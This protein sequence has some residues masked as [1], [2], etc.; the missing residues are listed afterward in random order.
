[1]LDPVDNTPSEQIQDTDASTE[2]ANESSSRGL[3]DE[4]TESLSSAAPEATISRGVS[5]TP[6]SFG[7]SV[8]GN[9]FGNPGITS[10]PMRQFRATRYTGTP[11]FFSKPKSGRTQS[12]EQTE[13]NR[14]RT[15]RLEEQTQVLQE[16]GVRLER[17]AD[18]LQN[19]ISRLRQ[20][21]S[22]PVKRRLEE[23]NAEKGKGHLIKVEEPVAPRRSDRNKDKPVVHY[24]K[25]KN[26]NGYI[27]DDY[28]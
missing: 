13:N 19:R 27:E 17:D 4:V 28:I 11:G 7:E 23:I 5:E 1:M 6:E 24:F 14:T 9:T 16:T 2:L 26:P 10:T 25:E 18:G 12:A 22:S 15:L 21:L 3:D 8:P 20:S